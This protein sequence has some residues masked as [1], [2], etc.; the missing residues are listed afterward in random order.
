MPVGGFP[1][2]FGQISLTPALLRTLAEISEPYLMG[3]LI[4]YMASPYDPSVEGPIRYLQLDV[5]YMVLSGNAI[6]IGMVI[7]QNGAY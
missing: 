7:R 1:G 5:D 3:T 4:H 2:A 6:G